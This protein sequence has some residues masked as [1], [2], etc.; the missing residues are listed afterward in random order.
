LTPRGCAPL[1][2]AAPA[3]GQPVWR[4]PAAGNAVQPMS[5]RLVPSKALRY[6]AAVGGLPLPRLR[7]S[8]GKRLQI[9]APWLAPACGAA[10]GR[11]VPGTAQCFAKRVKSTRNARARGTT[12]IVSQPTRPAAAA[13]RRPDSA[14]VRRSQCLIEP[15]NASRRPGTSELR[16]SAQPRDAAAVAE[17]AQQPVQQLADPCAECAVSLVFSVGM[18]RYK[19]QTSRA[20]R[21]VHDCLAVDGQRQNL[22]PAAKRLR[23]HKCSDHS[24]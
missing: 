9:H 20:C 2:G 22:G 5:R 16:S 4:A 17:P 13:V 6:S 14:K 1:W 12:G 11:H 19:W 18:A 23:T 8:H 3:A 21:R 7:P 15:G 10:L 24:N